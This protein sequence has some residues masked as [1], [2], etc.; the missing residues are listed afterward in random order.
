MN[1]LYAALACTALVLAAACSKNQGSTSPSAASPSAPSTTLPV[2]N[3]VTFD[4]NDVSVTTSGPTILRLGFVIHNNSKDPVQCDP[5]EFSI[6]LSDGTVVAAD[7]SADN[8]C[9]PDFIDPH[10]TGNGLVFFDLA[11][12]Y[13]GPVTLSMTAGDAVVGKGTTTLK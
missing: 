2:R 4:F 5:S 9:A 12:S 3:D 7:Q 6:Q 10:T 1:R 11:T 13:T 8:K